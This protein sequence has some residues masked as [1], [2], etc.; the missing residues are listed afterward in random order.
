MS[1]VTRGGGTKLLFSAGPSSSQES[2][3]ALANLPSFDAKNFSKFLPSSACRSG[4]GKR[5]SVYLPLNDQP[6]TQ[7]ITSEKTNILLRWVTHRLG[8]GDARGGS[9]HSVQDET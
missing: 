3:S 1:N 7:V 4:G 2:K 8:E 5:P 9:S 6:H